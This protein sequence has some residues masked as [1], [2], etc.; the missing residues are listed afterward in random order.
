MKKTITL[1]CTLILGFTASYAAA[2]AQTADDISIL[3]AKSVTDVFSDNE[4][5]HPPIKLSPDKSELVRLDSKASSIIVGNPA[6]LSVLA[7]SAELLVFIPKLPGATYVTVL[8]KN[9]EII[10]QRHVIIAGPEKKYLRIRQSCATSKDKNCQRTQVF[11]CP[12]VCH[13]V[14]L[15]SGEDD[16]SSDGA[17]ATTPSGTTPSPQDNE[18]AEGSTPE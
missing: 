10:M 15:P 13:P 1:L 4:I 9:G 17:T 7:E 18:D 14:V 12:D 5:T 2:L 16:A 8:D 11:Y 6:H 3:P